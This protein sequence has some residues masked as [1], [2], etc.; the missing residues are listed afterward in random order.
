MSTNTVEHRL[1][2]VLLAAA[3]GMCVFTSLELVL[4]EHFESATQLIPFVL[5]GVGVL[6]ILAVWVRPQRATVWALRLVMG[7]L[8]AGS[9]LGVWEH[10]QGNLA[11]ALEIRPN[12]TSSEVWL[13][14]LTGA[15]PLLAPGI[16]AL[17][18]ILAF[19]ATYAHPAM[20]R[21]TTTRTED[22]YGRRSA[23]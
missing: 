3:A 20:L 12:A 11:F 7:L 2:T 5:C 1:R 14:A 22:A 23:N 13:E 17:A 15:N 16:L 10:I 21:R 19:A 4:A 8:L 9:A 18:G 6:A